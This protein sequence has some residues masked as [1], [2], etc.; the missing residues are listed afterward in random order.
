MRVKKGG[1]SAR[2]CQRLLTVGFEAGGGVLERL[3]GR[4]RLERRRQRLCTLNANL[5][6]GEAANKSQTEVS[7]AADTC[8]LVMCGQEGRLAV[9]S[10]VWSVEFALRPSERCLAASALRLLYPR[11]QTKSRTEVSAAAD[12]YVSVMCG[13]EGQLAAYSSVWSVEF[14]LRPSKRCLVASALRP[15]WLRLRT[16]AAPSTGVEETVVWNVSR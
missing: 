8:V 13:Q 7:A 15:L 14:A 12:T 2:G 5:V 10:S 3:K 1:F 4:V 9:Y 6:V 16:R 11:L